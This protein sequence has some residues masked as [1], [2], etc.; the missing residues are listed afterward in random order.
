MINNYS[1]DFTKVSTDDEEIDE[2]LE[3][4]DGSIYELEE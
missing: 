3:Q 1:D 4:E 2:F